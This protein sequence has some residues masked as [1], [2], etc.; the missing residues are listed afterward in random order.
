MRYFRA[1]LWLMALSVPADAEQVVGLITQTA[2]A[3]IVRRGDQSQLNAVNGDVL[4]K[5]D[6]LLI[7][8]GASGSAQFQI[9]DSSGSFRTYRIT[10]GRATLQAQTVEGANEVPAPHPGSLCFL[11]DL[12][13]DPAIGMMT[14][15][16][17]DSASTA[18]ASGADVPASALATMNPA[19]R[20]S[21]Q[22]V[23]SALKSDPNDLTARL[24]RAVLL[25]RNGLEE[26]A[27]ADLLSIGKDWPDE[28]WARTLGYSIATRK[29]TPNAGSGKLYAAFVG[30]SKYQQP[31]IPGLHYADAD[32]QLFLDFMARTR[33]Q[34]FA[35]DRFYLPLINENANSTAVRNKLKAFFDQAQQSDSVLLY[36]AAHGV[37]DNTS[38][39]GYVVLYD[40][41]LESTYANSLS[42]DWIRELL[43]AEAARV[44]HVF[45]FVDTCHANRIGPIRQFASSDSAVAKA[46][47]IV[48]DGKILAM[49]ASGDNQFSFENARYGG[50]HGA[51]TYF[52]MRAMN[53][54]PQDPDYPRAD[55]NGDGEIDAEELVSYVEDRVKADT[56]LKQIPK[57]DARIDRFDVSTK[58]P[59]LVI[60]PC[61]GPSKAAAG[62]PVLRDP[63][64]DPRGIQW[65]PPPDLEQRSDW[66]EKSQQVLYKYLQGE[67]VPQTESDYAAGLDATEQARRL[68]GESLYL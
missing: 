56:K 29:S 9:C 49:Y 31:N 2:G 66:E 47:K 37:G 32:A 45:L 25:R 19:D 17:L 30:I 63:T 34:V 46:A 62:A 68:A 57:D 5:G 35:S 33:A 21:L 8:A 43:L 14:E 52:L 41:H 48:T 16:A 36:I 40:T 4:F 13:T 53:I 6:S 20:A 12:E 55:V 15:R 38:D 61:C 54:T 64:L 50:G 7:P 3:Q 59:G 11:P 65:T 10:T 26:A 22:K 18:A 42:M 60:A 39:S 24:S 28:Q 23:E 1:I 27:A 58:L 44:S 51:F 67:E